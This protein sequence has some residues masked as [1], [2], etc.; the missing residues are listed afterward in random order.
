MDANTSTLTITNVNMSH[1]GGY[2]CTARDDED[3][4]INSKVANLTVNCKCTFRGKHSYK[5]EGLV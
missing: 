5:Y 4:D 1:A 2:F 3:M